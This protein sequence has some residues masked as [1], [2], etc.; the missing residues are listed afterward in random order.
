MGQHFSI[1]QLTLS[2]HFGARPNGRD[3][4]KVLE[5]EFDRAIFTSVGADSVAATHAAWKVSDDSHEAQ[6]QCG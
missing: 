1:P 2:A 3:R 5:S 6:L 4:Y